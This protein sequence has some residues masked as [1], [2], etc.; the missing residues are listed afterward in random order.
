MPIRPGS[1]I[2]DRY[3]LGAQLGTGGMARVYLAHDRVLDRQVAVKVLSENYAADPSFVERFRREASA[4]AGLNHPNIVAVYD[5]GEADGSYYIVMEYL[6]GP[7]LKQVIRRRAP[8]SPTVA[9]D[10]ALQILAALGA[11]HRRD[12]IHRDVKPQNVMVDEDGNLKVTDFGIARAGEGTQMTEAGSVIGT[13]QYLSPEGARG[14]E[15][16][17]ASDCYCVGII[18]YEMLTGGVPFD[19][20]RAVAVAMKQVNEPPVPPR[21]YEPDI[22]PALEAVVLRALEKRP[23]DRFRTA[24]EFSEALLAVRAQL[25]GG[26]TAP[27]AVAAAAAAGTTAATQVLSGNGGNSGTGGAEPPDD[28]PPRRPWGWIVLGGM[29]L[30]IVIV[31]AAL[32]LTSGGDGGG[33]VSVPDVSGQTVEDATAA[34][35]GAGLE[36][37]LESVDDPDAEPGTVIDTDPA[38]GTEVE[39]GST[40]T[41]RVGGGSN[42][43]VPDVIGLREA[44]ARRTLEGAGFVVRSRDEEDP[45]VDPGLV[46]SQNPRAGDQAASGSTVTIAVSAGADQ[47]QV[48]DVR[49]QSRGSAEATLSDA[50]LGVS[51]AEQAS[52]ATAGTV[53]G[54]SPSPGT[55]V[56]SGA[57][58]TITVAVDQPIVTVPNVVGSSAD[59]AVGTLSGAGLNP[60]SETASS[61]QPAG[62]VL[63]QSPAA[64]T[65][66]SGG[67]T[68]AITVS[69]G[70]SGSGGATTGG[71]QPPPPT[72]TGGGGGGTTTASGGSQPPPPATDSNPSGEPLP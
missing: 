25:S 49:G 32:A 59:A 3:E 30:A 31:V 62:T 48:P 4:A 17:A 10:N 45:R 34:L 1:V 56:D 66:V 2:G 18:L 7:D 51:V 26:V 5:R 68:V 65:E 8:L 15:V 72:T 71:S 42:V 12:V 37:Q 61:S 64:G 6:P 60:V 14:E 39:R 63:S 57:T 19:G 40:V 70:G 9:I 20:D 29:I 36:T 13:A 58:V 35:T 27:T 21:V 67:T 41:L 38:A 24:E 22:P 53:I 69:S 33:S 52:Q 50:G 47:V 54:Q 28:E 23:S 44:A 43:E 46:V 11:A 16:T 55:T